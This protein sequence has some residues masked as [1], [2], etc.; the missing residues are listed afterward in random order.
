MINLTKLMNSYKTTTLMAGLILAGL[1]SSA[2]VAQATP[3]ET[4]APRAD[5]REQ[6]K[7]S[8][9][10]VFNGDNGK[11][12]RLYL[13]SMN[14]WMVP[15]NGPETTSYKSNVVKVRWIDNVA[16][17]DA[18]QAEW[19]G[20]LGQIYWQQGSPRDYRELSDKGAALS[21]VLRVDEK[22]RKTVDLKM[23]CGYPCAGTLNMTRL[24]K[25][26]PEN[27]WFRISLKLSCFEASGANMANI[28]APLVVATKDNF[29]L[30]I[31]DVRITM[32]PPPES[33]VAC[34]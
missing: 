23:D 29:T 22:P 20:G 7:T 9:E 28:L 15:I 4:D 12:W 10:I 25:A 11:P 26:V 21:I 2:A 34:N 17:L 19:N 3:A 30:S 32:N 6:A 31:S 33:V 16:E 5:T 1:I 18:I 24:L 14:N 13:G 8:D 27:Q